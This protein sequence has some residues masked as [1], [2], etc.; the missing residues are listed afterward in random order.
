[1]AKPASTRVSAAAPLGGLVESRSFGDQPLGTARSIENYFPTDPKNGRLRLAMRPGNSKFSSAQISGSNKVHR[2]VEL[3]YHNPAQIT[4][5]A[6]ATGAHL[7]AWDKALDAKRPCYAIISDAQGNVYAI[8]GRATVVKYNSAG[9]EIVR[10]G[11]A[12]EDEAGL[13]RALA[14]DQFGVVYLGVSEGGDPKKAKLWAYQPTESGKYELRWELARP[15]DEDDRPKIHGFV[16][17]AIERDGFLYTVQNNTT[18]ERAYVVVYGNLVSAEPDVDREAETAYP[19]NGLGIKPSGEIVVTGQAN[20]DRYVDPRFPEC[21]KS[22]YERKNEPGHKGL[23]TPVDL[24]SYEARIWRNHDADDI[25]GLQNE[26]LDGSEEI[27]E[28]VDLSGK[29]RTLRKATGVSGPIFDERNLGFRPAVKFGDNATTTKLASGGAGNEA[30]AARNVSQTLVPHWDDTTGS[31]AGYGSHYTAFLVIRPTQEATRGIVFAHEDGAGNIWRLVSNAREPAAYTGA[32]EPLVT[33]AGTCV[34]RAFKNA[35]GTDEADCGGTTGGSFD[36]QAQAMV[37]TIKVDHNL[38]TS[39]VRMNGAAVQVHSAAGGAPTTFA[40]TPPE[41]TET[42]FIGDHTVPIDSPYDGTIHDLL[43]FMADNG[44]AVVLSASE[45]EQVE[46]FLAWRRGIPNLLAGAHAYD[47]GNAP[48]RRTNTAAEAS[49][50][51]LLAIT[52]AYVA[53]YTSTLDLVW[54]YDTSLVGAGGI[55]YGAVCLSNGDIVTVGPTNT[56]NV[57]LRRIVDNGTTATFNVGAGYEADFGGSNYTYAYP[58]MVIDKADNVYL[59]VYGLATETMRV[60]TEAIALLTTV[61]SLTGDP[62]G[63]AIALGPTPKYYGDVTDDR[64]EYCFLASNQVGGAATDKVLHRIN[65]VSRAVSSSALPR[66]TVRVGVA[67]GAIKKFTTTTSSDPTGGPH[68]LDANAK[69]IGAVAALSRVWFADG[70]QYKV[71]NPLKDDGTEE[72]VEWKSKSAGEIAPGCALLAVWR[73]R[74]VLAADPLAPQNW[75]MS[76]QLD[77][78]NWDEFPVVPLATQAISG[79]NAEAGMV[80]DIVTALMPYSDDYLLFGGDKSLWLMRGDPMAGG[81][82]DLVSDQTGVAF[83]DAWCKDPEGNLYFFGS[84]GGIFVTNVGGG[85]VDLTRDMIDRRLSDI[86]LSA[87]RAV[88]TW[89]TE[90]DGLHLCFVP[91]T[92]VAS[93]TVTTHY[94]WSKRTGGIFPWTFSRSSSP[95]NQQ[96]TSVLVIDGDAVADRK[97]LFGC[98][99]GYVR[100]WERTLDTDDGVVVDANVFY[101][102]ALADEEAE[103]GIQ[104]LEV[105]LAEDQGPATYK[106]YASHVPDAL[107]QIRAAGT[108]KNGRN[109]AL[110]RA[111]GSYVWLELSGRSR[112]AI[113]SVDLD[114]VRLGHKRMV[115]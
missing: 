33:A 34:F 94:F 61:N 112:H 107:G 59:P 30:F 40:G 31:G 72:V 29:G 54:A 106:L 105:V 44:E 20:A 115:V 43:V 42:G 92:T 102:T 49:W 91:W 39:T 60:Y 1:M 110:V 12:I 52:N 89:D 5:S 82:L 67:N 79:N 57:V 18:S 78:E 9:E 32:S 58:R 70:R 27:L 35:G 90:F 108:L 86:D 22:P 95:H 17:Q 109:R 64:A 73:G 6:V 48:P 3:T 23:W 24:D 2:L 47:F 100:K 98:Q 21:V 50:R 74:A 7:A 65:L 76:K 45:I 10:F 25:D 26:S 96:V 38:A 41:H 80:P 111:G 83:G 11:P 46:G 87:Y 104:A 51:V 53:K 68:T 14:V 55:G 103:I 77:F 15:E 28:W 97:L 13:C 93:G 71:Y 37:V 4:Y 81:V 88:L 75:H 16:E 8:D 101:M 113:E 36:N 66:A 85:I 56:N 84:R 99:D 19:V 114:V 69:Y 63:H 62:Q